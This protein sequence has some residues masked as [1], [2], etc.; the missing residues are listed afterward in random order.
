MKKKFYILLVLSVFVIGNFIPSTLA[1][2]NS[3]LM[4]AIKMYKGG[5][6]SGCY[7]QLQEVI[8]NEPANILAYYYMGMTA[9]QIGRKDEA[10]SYYDKVLSL[11]P[12][13]NNLSRYAEKGKLCLEDAE[14]CVNTFAKTLDEELIYAPSSKKFSKEVEDQF[15]KLKLDNFRREMNRNDSIDVNKFKE[16]KDF[17]SAPT[18]DEIVAAMR[19]LQRAGLENFGNRGY[20]DLS[21]LTGQAGPNSM[22]E[23]M[24]SNTMNPQLI[25]ALLTNSVVQGF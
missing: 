11:S 6:Y 7:T 19:V 12:G 24:H 10:I 13:Q 9:A 14:S 4:E 25:Q 22:L 15:E 2:G 8:K 20:S 18:N 16:Y 1:K 5:N 17:S 23:M 21:V 3:D